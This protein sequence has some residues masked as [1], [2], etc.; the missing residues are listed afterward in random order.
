MTPNSRRTNPLASLI[1]LTNSS[2]Q[3][4]VAAGLHTKRDLWGFFESSDTFGFDGGGVKTT[5]LRDFAA[6]T[7]CEA[8][9]SQPLGLTRANR[10]IL[11][12]S[13]QSKFWVPEMILLAFPLL[14]FFDNVFVQFIDSKI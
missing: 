11:I 4:L 3:H 8:L 9:D 12:G 13:C 14:I 6:E 1:A 10:A 7:Q 2:L 5:E